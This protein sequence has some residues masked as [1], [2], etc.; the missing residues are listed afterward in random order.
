MSRHLPSAWMVPSA[1]MVQSWT[2]L[3]SQPAMTTGVALAPVPG[4]AHLALRYPETIG[5]VGLAGTAGVAAA[6]PASATARTAG[7]AAARPPRS[8]SRRPGRRPA[9]LPAPGAGRTVSRPGRPVA[10]GWTIIPRT[11]PPVLTEG[12]HSITLSS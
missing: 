11:W 6:G 8:A 2:V 10:P 1:S 12:D 4:T 3:P 7:T 9:D 5:P